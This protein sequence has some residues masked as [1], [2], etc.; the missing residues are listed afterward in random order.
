MYNRS[1]GCWLS[2]VIVVIFS[3]L[4]KVALECHEE[5]SFIFSSLSVC[6]F[7]F[8]CDI[9]G[10]EYHS[11]CSK[12]IPKILTQMCLLTVLRC[13]FIPYLKISCVFELPSPVIAVNNILLHKDF[14]FLC[15]LNSS[16]ILFISRDVLENNLPQGHV[17]SWWRSQSLW[18]LSLTIVFWYK[19]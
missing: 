3:C 12:K 16:E 6:Y 9:L 13:I 11:H 10:E 1:V 2:T 15:I 14:T 7:L 17:V 8:E 18:E 5:L 4:W 19:H